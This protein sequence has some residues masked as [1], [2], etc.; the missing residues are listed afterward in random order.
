[1]SQREPEIIEIED[2]RVVGDREIS[3]LVDDEEPQP[4]YAN[5]VWVGEMRS[6]GPGCCF[7]L[8]LTVTLI[9]L[10]FLLGLCAALWLILQA[11]GWLVP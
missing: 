10:I 11:L 6:A 3:T 5:P 2:W 9:L 1:M 4:Q 7:G 8:S